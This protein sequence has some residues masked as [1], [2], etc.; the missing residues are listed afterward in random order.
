MPP[1]SSSRTIQIYASTSSASS[2]SSGNNLDI[3]R[4]DLGGERAGLEATGALFSSLGGGR[5]STNASAASAGAGGGDEE[6]LGLLRQQLSAVQRIRME[7]ERKDATIAALRLEVPFIPHF[8]VGA[9]F[10]ATLFQYLGSTR[11][12]IV[13]L[14]P[15]NGEPSLEA[16]RNFG[17]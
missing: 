1:R 12:V 13:H 9:L 10:T 17:A 2:A 4:Q 11:S 14:R 8:K 6:G 3:Q 15:Q 16:T 7:H 5:D